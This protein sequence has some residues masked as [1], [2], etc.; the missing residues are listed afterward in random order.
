MIKLPRGDRL[1]PGQ[2]GHSVAQCWSL[3]F[4]Q[5]GLEVSH[6][7][8]TGM[9][10]CWELQAQGQQERARL[11]GRISR[12]QRSLRSLHFIGRSPRT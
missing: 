3:L 2:W 11:G 7:W 4:L 10:P 5:K 1:V 9:Q 8:F 6:A 12:T